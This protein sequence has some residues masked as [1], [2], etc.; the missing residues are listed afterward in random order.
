MRSKIAQ[1]KIA[2]ICCSALPSVGGMG[3]SA[4][5]HAKALR[6]MGHEV[7]LLSLPPLPEGGEGIS[8]FIK[9]GKAAWGATLENSL[10]GVDIVHLHLPFFGVA[11]S[12]VKWE[13]D[14]PD[15]PLLATYH[16]DAAGTGFK[17]KYI[18]WW[19]KNRLQKV[20]DACNAVA[21]TSK[22]YTRGSHLAAAASIDKCREIPLRVDTD[23]FKPAL[24]TLPEDYI[25][26]VGGLDSAHY[27]KG[28]DV[29]LR[30]I[31]QTSAKLWIVGDGERK[32]EYKRMAQKLGIQERVSFRGRLSEEDLL[33]AYQGAR[34]LVLPSTDGSEAFGLVLIEA[35]ACGTPVIASDLPGVRRV[36]GSSGA[37]QLVAPGDVHMLSRALNSAWDHP[38]TKEKRE[39]I[40]NTAT[41]QYALSTLGADLVAW[42]KSVL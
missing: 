33:R 4:Y 19:Y 7:R 42:Y 26:F 18:S 35:L 36:V 6:A 10:K 13:M 41:K 15:I 2:Q 3:R 27:F 8:H 25:L 20:V 12:V 31:A 14:H 1:M 37:G 21:V 5:N 29:L 40:A 11:D 24:E 38:P 30:A 28:V 23:F 16:M 34:A 9:I 22:D 17:K 32:P 39:T